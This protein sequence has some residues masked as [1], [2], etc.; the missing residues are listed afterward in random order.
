MSKFKILSIENKL[1]IRITRK[2]YFKVNIA[3]LELLSK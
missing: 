2:F 1:K 3:I